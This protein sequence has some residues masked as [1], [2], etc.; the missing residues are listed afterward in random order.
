VSETDIPHGPSDIHPIPACAGYRDGW[1]RLVAYLVYGTALFAAFGLIQSVARGE[2]LIAAI[3]LVTV[4]TFIVTLFHEAGH[5]AA[6]LWL[7]GRV[8]VFSVGPICLKFR[9]LRISA[10]PALRDRE[11]G[12]FVTYSFQGWETMRKELAVAVAG[13]A[14]NVVLALLAGLMTAAFIPERSPVQPQRIAVVADVERESETFIVAPLPSKEAMERAARDRKSKE[15]R[16]FWIAILQAVMMLSIGTAI[17]NM[18]PFRGS[19]G[20]VLRRYM[21]DRRELR[22][23]RARR[24]QR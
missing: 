13:P 4:L 17:A 6:V 9:P 16:T 15:S 10:T 18:L 1:I 7:R 8:L 23:Y 24:E 19:D 22:Q 20:E 3:M 14:A 11:V 21:R 2:L 12:G 5:A